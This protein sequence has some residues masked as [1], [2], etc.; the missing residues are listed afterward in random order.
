MLEWLNSRRASMMS[1]QQVSTVLVT[2]SIVGV[3]WW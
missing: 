3:W 2:S 1:Y